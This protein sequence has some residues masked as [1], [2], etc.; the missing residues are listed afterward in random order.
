MGSSDFIS[1]ELFLKCRMQYED[2][3]DMLLQVLTVQSIQFQVGIIDEPFHS[4]FSKVEVKC[5]ECHI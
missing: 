3:A 4:Y 1:G 2:E 5:T